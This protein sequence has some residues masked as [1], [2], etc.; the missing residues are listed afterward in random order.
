MEHKKTLIRAT[1]NSRLKALL[2]DRR[3][4]VI[5]IRDDAKK[6]RIFL[7]KSLL[8]EYKISDKIYNAWSKKLNE[9]KKYS[10]FQANA[11][12]KKK[13]K[14]PTTTRKPRS[15]VKSPAGRRGRS[16]TRS[17]SRSRSR[18]SIRKK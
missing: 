18:S 4:V 11:A 8:R 2:K 1:V 12:V 9:I 15:R 13:K 3:V 7:P 16:R 14:P 17:R 10:I 5:F 6:A